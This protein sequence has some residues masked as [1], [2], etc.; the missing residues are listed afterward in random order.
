MH[1]SLAL[2]EVLESIHPTAATAQPGH[3]LPTCYR[4]SC[5]GVHTRLLSTAL[6]KRFQVL[7]TS[8]ESQQAAVA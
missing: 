8:T 6:T 5:A 1:V 2:F 3:D 4:P 7:Y